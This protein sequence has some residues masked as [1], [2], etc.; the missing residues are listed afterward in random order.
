MKNTMMTL[1]EMIDTAIF[2][3]LAHIGGFV[4]LNFDKIILS[5]VALIGIYSFCTR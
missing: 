3:L 4:L 2:N 5:I 1:V